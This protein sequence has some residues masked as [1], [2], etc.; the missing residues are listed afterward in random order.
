MRGKE[1]RARSVDAV[2]CQD[3]LGSVVSLLSVS[4]DHWWDDTDKG[5]PKY[6]ES[7]RSQCRIFCH[8]TH[9][10]W[11]EIDPGPPC[12]WDT[13]T[14][15]SFWHYSYQSAECLILLCVFVLVFPLFDQTN[16]LFGLQNIL[17]FLGLEGSC[18]FLGAYWKTDS[19]SYAF[20]ACP[21]CMGYFLCFHK[22][23]QFISICILSRQVHPVAVLRNC[24]AAACVALGLVCLTSKRHFLSTKHAADSGQQN[25]ALVLFYDR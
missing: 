12:L 15:P 10:G 5:N 7:S 18:L 24:I 21:A 14:T 3:Y 6:S 4:M 19:M 8:K 9:I 11:P 23:V 16:G 1:W 20:F 17:R 13:I 25:C 2:S 22:Y